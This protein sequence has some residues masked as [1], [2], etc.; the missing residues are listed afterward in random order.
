MPEMTIDSKIIS[1]ISNT[2]PFQ[3]VLVLSM[4]I[5]WTAVYAITII[6]NHK[7]KIAAMPWLAL[8]LNISWELIY[9]F[10]IPYPDASYRYGIFFWVALDSVMLVQGLK[11][12][13]EDFDHVLPGMQKFYYPVCIGLFIMMLA[14]VWSSNYQWTVLPD[15]AGYTAYIMN[16]MMSMLYIVTLFRRTNTEKGISI[17]IAICKFWGSL[18]PTL[19]GMIYLPGRYIFPYTLGIITAILDIIYIIL[20]FRHFKKLGL[21]PFTRKKI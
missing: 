8:C 17:W 10:V 21:N 3:I 15:P 7:D 13:R 1:S 18:A 4:L 6:R 2:T 5:C 19:L 20:V 11:Y 14:C 16:L 9:S 12:G